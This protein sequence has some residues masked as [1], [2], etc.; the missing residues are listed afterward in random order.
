VAHHD[1]VINWTKKEFTKLKVG[2]TFSITSIDPG[3]FEFAFPGTLP[4]SDPGDKARRRKTSQFT[5]TAPGKHPYDCFLNG[6]KKIFAEDAEVAG[7]IEVLP[8]D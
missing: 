7:E 2:D 1:I 3:T 5:A 8:G 4:F 6:K